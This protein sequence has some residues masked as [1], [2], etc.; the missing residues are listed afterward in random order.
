MD[1]INRK[2]I[3]RRAVALICSCLFPVAG[4][5]AD[6]A[7]ALRATVDA[8][9]RPVMAEHD[10]PGMGGAVTVNGGEAALFKL[11]A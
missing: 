1:L 11:Q 9:I 6:D 2:R 7:P 3:C 4:W 10:V 8:A 5:A